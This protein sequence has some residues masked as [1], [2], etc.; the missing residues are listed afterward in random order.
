MNSQLKICILFEQFPLC[1]SAEKI[2]H[3]RESILQ[4]NQ[5][6]IIIYV[7]FVVHVTLRHS[8]IKLNLIP[9]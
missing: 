3:F 1:A 4:H 7:S 6:R 8:N 9:N 2:K 5:H